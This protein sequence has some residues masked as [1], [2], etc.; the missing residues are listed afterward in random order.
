MRVDRVQRE[1]HGG[2]AGC[3]ASRV[4]ADRKRRRE[5][6]E[7]AGKERSK[8]A[9]RASSEVLGMNGRVGQGTRR[10]ATCCCQG[11]V[12]KIGRVAHCSAAQADSDTFRSRCTPARRLLACPRKDAHRATAVPPS[13]APPASAVGVFRL[14]R[15]CSGDR[16]LLGTPGPKS[17]LPAA[18][19][20]AFW[21]RQHKG[22]QERRER[23]YVTIW[24]ARTQLVRMLPVIA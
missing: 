16:G 15:R 20:S 13:S 23:R 6:A 4:R 21:Q 11:R 14:E 24:L 19:R 1:G 9:A 17:T 10:A 18:P 22:R 12:S 2:W 8:S 7:R 3:S 5:A